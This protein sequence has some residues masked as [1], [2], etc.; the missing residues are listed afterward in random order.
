[1]SNWTMF[2]SRTIY[3]LNDGTSLAI[4]S[5]RRTTMD[6]S[7]SREALIEFLAYLGDKGLIAKPTAQARKA[8][9]SKILSILDAEE[10]RDITA[11][12]LD[13]VVSRFGNI[14]GKSYTPGSLN[15][16]KSRLVS[17]IED[18]K[19]YVANPLAFRPAV[20]N[21]ERSRLKSGGES[22]GSPKQTSEPRREEQKTV[23][24]MA[25][26]IVPI[27]LRSDLTIFIQGLPFDLT[28]GEARKIAAVVTAMALT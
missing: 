14:H 27:P 6:G 7:R 2:M 28:E 10:A 22:E 5:S 15:T 8:T 21:R 23:V 13:Q 20:Q 4:S 11:L 18:F 24:S 17:S 12:D 16:Y 19:S 3:P 25:P 26:N 9:A 1:M